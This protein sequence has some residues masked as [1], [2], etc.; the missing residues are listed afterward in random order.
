M[1]AS[2]IARLTATTVR[3]IRYYHGLGL[4]P[5]PAERGGWRDYDLAHVARLSR[6]RWLVSAGV[7]L[8]SV[9]RI[10]DGDQ[11]DGAGAACG[12]GQAGP[13]AA[14]IVTDL[15]GALTALDEHLAEVT[16]QREMLRGLLSRAR[17]GSTV[18]PMPARVADFFDRLQRAAPDERTR[19]AVRR[20]RDLVDVAYYRGQMPQEAELLFWAGDERHD[21]VVLAA[22]GREVSTLSDEQVEA[23]AAQNVR[24]MEERL[25][26][27]RSRAL[28]RSV[29]EEAV[30][31]FFRLTDLIEPSDVRLTR[32]M[33]R[34]VLAAIS[35]LR[36]S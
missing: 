9:A 16:A 31:S 36:A 24:R 27:E 26:P 8:D 32:A 12:S 3:T 20:E 21:A 17:Q 29:D 5:V 11:A 35:R 14:D 18:S 28:A 10:L 6:I 13:G 30:R 33:E 4:L 22:Y 23:H 2:Q 34:Q 25:G 19:T 7:P 1:R 15:S